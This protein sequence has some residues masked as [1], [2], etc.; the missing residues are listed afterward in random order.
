[1]ENK[2]VF[3]NHPLSILL[4][5]KGSIFFFLIFTNAFLDT[6]KEILSGKRNRGFFEN[7]KNLFRDNSTAIWILLGFLV[8]IVLSILYQFFIYKNTTLT[9]DNNNIYYN[10]KGIFL[11]K[12]KTTLIKNISN[13]N[14]Q[15]SLLQKIFGLVNISMDTDSTETI[16]TSDY[17]LIVKEKQAI[18]I[19]NLINS[20]KVE[21]K[22]YVF[23]EDLEKIDDDYIVKTFSF[24]QVIRH[25][26]LSFSPLFAL[27]Q[28]AIFLV[29]VFLGEL[30]ETIFIPIIFFVFN[31][32]PFIVKQLNS[33]N[34]L[35]ITRKENEIDIYYGFLKTEHFSVPVEK[36]QSLET[37]Q[38]FFARI[39]KYKIYK[40]NAVGVGNDKEESNILNLYLKSQDADENLREILPEFKF[41]NEF[42]GQNKNYIKYLAIIYAIFALIYS[43]ILIYY[44]L[45]WVSIILDLLLIIM[46]IFQLKYNYISVL[47]NRLV[48][49]RGLFSLTTRTVY[50]KKVDT[51][52]VH[53]NILSRIFKIQKLHLSFRGKM[54]KDQIQTG[55]FKEGFFD[56]IVEFY[57]N[58]E[59]SDVAE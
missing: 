23:E 9:I 10:K 16:K 13:I 44:N 30:K 36:I 38:S 43:P 4:N 40:I 55:Y 12:Y 15:S 45:W 37:Y 11:K 21:N 1:M 52:T 59:K 54:G 47:N 58:G 8:L 27:F 51:I 42:I 34:N 28:I 20:L 32:V 35:K 39:F 19:K 22:D 25:I 14:I 7:I 17:E 57:R 24:G 41:E 5:N 3:K 29:P 26:L 18:L 46:V 50:Y 48:I 56:K 31:V 33:T 2:R 6:I 53:Q 49:K